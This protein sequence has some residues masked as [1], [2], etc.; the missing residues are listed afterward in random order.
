MIYLSL[1]VLH[2]KTS[3]L[4]GLSCIHIG[5]MNRLFSFALVSLGLGK[6][7]SR[8]HLILGGPQLAGQTIALFLLLQEE[9]C[10]NLSMLPSEGFSVPVKEQVV[11]N[12]QPVYV[13]WPSSFLLSLSG[14]VLH[15]TRH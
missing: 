11:I 3:I 8:L 12:L 14:P 4:T 9:G 1:S 5:K 2:G 15:K 13:S 10:K 7:I 6:V